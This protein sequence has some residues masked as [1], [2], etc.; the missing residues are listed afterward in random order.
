M[1]ACIQGLNGDGF[2]G[3]EYW[4]PD[5][6][7][8]AN[9]VEYE[10]F[11]D[12]GCTQPAKDY[13]RAHTINGS[14]ETQ[15]LVISEYQQGNSTPADV[16][17]ENS[18]TTGQFDPDGYPVIG[19]GFVRSSS[20]TEQ[21]NGTTVVTRDSEYIV[22]ASSRNGTNFCGDSAG[23]NDEKLESLG[24]VSGWQNLLANGSRTVNNDGSTTWST[25]NA[26]GSA[27]SAV[28]GQFSVAQGTLNTACPISTPAFTLNGGTLI[29]GYSVPSMS[30]TFKGGV[31][32]NLT[33]T[34]ATLT[35][36]LTL[37]V[38]TNTAESPTNPSF[39]SGVLSKGRTSVATFNVDAF[40]NGTL[41]VGATGLT[42][43]MH[44]WHVTHDGKPSK[45]PAPSPSAS[46]SPVASAT[47]TA[48]PSAH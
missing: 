45:S 3:F 43:E 25:T 22:A 13:I 46:A 18:T 12:G 31:L 40:G 20:Y 44:H 11:Y 19:N 8:E 24:Q 23:F 15:K 29:S 33:I 7:G 30:A 37:N 41:V 10:M 47:P 1:G 39:N 38:T 35:N 28:P 17:T 9:S 42:Y 32:Q 21:E 34:N 27:Y 36:G 2:A 16:T 14:T 48:S 26:A 6:A 5:R 4:K